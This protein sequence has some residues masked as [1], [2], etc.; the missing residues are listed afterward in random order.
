MSAEPDALAVVNQLRDLAADPMNRRAIVQDQGCLPGLILFLDNPNPQVVYSALLAIRYLA[1]CRANREKLKG[2]LGMMLSLQNV[3]QKSTTPGE[4][5]LLASEIYELLQ[6]SSSA[7]T[8]QAEEPV[9]SRRKAQFFLGS[10]NKRAKT[11]ILH[12]DGLDDSSRRSLCEEALLK[13][14]GVIS[15]TFQMAVKRCIVRIRSDLKAEAL[16]SAIAS[17][18]VMTAQQVVKGESGDEV[19]IPFK[20]DGSVVVE[21]NVNLP[22]YLPEDESPSQEP[23]KAVSRVGSGQEGASWLGAAT[24]FLS[25][26]FYW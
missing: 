8:E 1:E 17:T 25:R 15:F 14:R 4:T 26:S 3:V 12:I 21:Q 20:E 9:S 23:D 6:A 19:L 7:D 18:Q 24:N 5:K 10:S 16:A 2:E 11:V 13:I 22:D